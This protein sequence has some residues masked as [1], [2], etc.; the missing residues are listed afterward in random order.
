MAV[1]EAQYRGG[2][3]VNDKGETFGRAYEGALESAVRSIY[4]NTSDCCIQ[5][6]SDYVWRESQF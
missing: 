3:A 4:L 6:D 5:C 1:F 2:K